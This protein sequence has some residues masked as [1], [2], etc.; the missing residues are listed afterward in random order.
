[1]RNRNMGL[2]VSRPAGR[3]PLNSKSVNACNI[4]MFHVLCHGLGYQKYGR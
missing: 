3:E 2:K 1:M 4:G